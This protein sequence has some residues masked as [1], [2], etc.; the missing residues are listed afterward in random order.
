M[1][2]ESGSGFGSLMPLLIIIGV[3]YMFFIAPGKRAKKQQS[4]TINLRREIAEKQKNILVVTSSAIH[5]KNITKVLGAVSGGS[6]TQIS[7]QDTHDLADKEA[8]LSILQEAE[9]LGANAIIDLQKN[10]SSYEQQG[11]K[12]HVSQI[13]YAGTAVRVEGD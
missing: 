3:I 8:M 4:K 11:S 1:S 12:W 9:S 2:A 10:S 13:S 5:G 7:T 6:R